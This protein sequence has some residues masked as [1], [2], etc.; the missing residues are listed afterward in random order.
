MWVWVGFITSFGPHNWLF[1]QAH[2]F[3]SVHWDVMRQHAGKTYSEDIVRKATLE[4][5]E[6][7]NILTLEGITVR[8]PDP[9][10]WSKE[11]STPD[12]TSTGTYRRVISRL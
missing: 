1:A 3:G 2:K 11:F 10:D 7:C 12:F 5:E 4:I 9:I 6:L 8:R